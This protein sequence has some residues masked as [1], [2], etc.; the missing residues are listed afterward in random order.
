M[1][2]SYK[3]LFLLV[4]STMLFA[5]QGQAVVRCL[6]SGHLSLGGATEECCDGCEAPPS[7]AQLNAAARFDDLGAQLVCGENCFLVATANSDQV[8]PSV[9]H[10]DAPAV[11]VAV[12]ASEP[13]YL[14]RAVIF[15]ASP[16]WIRTGLS[17][18]A[19]SGPS[20]SILYGA[21]LI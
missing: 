4:L 20:C 18:P 12:L 16:A 15:D 5:L 3:A 6:C 11:P 21:L 10:L 9:G 19:P 2:R 7:T 8:M 17:K 1:V 13:S 14:P